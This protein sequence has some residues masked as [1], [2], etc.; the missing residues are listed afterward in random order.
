MRWRGRLMSAGDSVKKALGAVLIVVAGATLLGF[1][2]V[3]ETALVEASPAWLTTLMTRFENGARIALR[4]GRRSIH[5]A[6]RR[7]AA[8]PARSR[9]VSSLRPI[10]AQAGQ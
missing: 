6:L 5:H 4:V 10:M 1:D 3:I 9:Y 7:T 2:R 8:G